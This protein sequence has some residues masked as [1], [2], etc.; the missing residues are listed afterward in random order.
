MNIIEQAVGLF[1]TQ[2]DYADAIGATEPYVSIC[3]RRGA[4]HSKYWRPTEKATGGKITVNML[5]EAIH[6]EQSEQ[7][8]A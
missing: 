8:V 7:D 4:I 2:K 5:C 6:P 1:P 3:R